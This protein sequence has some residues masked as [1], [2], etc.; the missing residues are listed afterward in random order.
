MMIREVF[1]AAMAQDPEIEAAMRAD[2]RAHRERDPACDRYFTPFLFF[3]GYH[4]L[5]AYRVGH[6][7][8]RSERRSLA[9]YLQHQISQ[10]VYVDMHPGARIGRGIMIDHA[11]GVVVGE[12]AVVEDNVS[13]LHAVTLGGTGREGGDRHP[14][15]REGLLISAGAKILS[16][17]DVGAGAK[18]GAGSEVLDSV[19]ARTTVAGVPARIVDRPRCESRARDMYHELNGNVNYGSAV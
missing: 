18:V 14:K 9:L 17:I 19:P 4:A 10:M 5:Q 13:I 2:I 15:I 7:L 3:K 12:T 8:W 16:N 1:D 6:C 11:A